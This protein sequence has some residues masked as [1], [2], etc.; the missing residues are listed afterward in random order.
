MIH[1]PTDG[2]E[3]CGVPLH[4]FFE[5]LAKGGKRCMYTQFTCEVAGDAHVVY[6]KTDLACG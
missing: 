2:I 6:G 5:M 4:V 1:V 3:N